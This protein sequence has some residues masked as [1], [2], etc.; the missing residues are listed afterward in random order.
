MFEKPTVRALAGYIDSARMDSSGSK[1]SHIAAIPRDVDLPL[2]FSQQRIWFLD[3][4]TGTST[5]Y[6]IP[7]AF[8]LKGKLDVDVLRRSIREIIARHEVLRTT[9]TEKDGKPVQRIMNSPA[10]DLEVIN[11]D[12]L[13][14]DERTT[15]IHRQI[16]EEAQTPFDL[17]QGPLI[18]F[19]LLHLAEME[20]ALFFTMHHI[21]F[22]R[23]S[24][25]V[26]NRELSLLYN[27]YCQ[28]QPSPL[29]ELPIQYADYAAWQRQW[30]KGEKLEEQL[31]FWKEQLRDITALELHSDRPR[32]P[33][34]TFNGNTHIFQISPSLTDALH[35][36]NRREGATLFMTLLAVFQ[37]L[38]HRYTGNDNIVVGTPI[39]NRNRGDIEGLIGFFINT[40]VIHTDISG[41]PTFREV[42][43]RVRKVMLDAY[44]HQDMPFEK[45]VE[46][47]Q[48]ERDMSRT[49][50]FQVAF[51]LQ[52]EPY[53]SLEFS[54][55]TVS[56]V[57]IESPTAMFD[58]EV[59]MREEE[60]GIR[61]IVVYNTDLFDL[62]TIER[63]TGHYHR[64]LSS[65]SESPDQPVS[66]IPMLT[67]AER[68][69]ILTEWNDTSMEYPGNKC[70]HELFEAYVEKTPDA[71]AVI[72]GDR[73]LTY[74]ELNERANQLA[75]YLKSQGV[76]PEVFAGICLER[77]P[78][79]L[80]GILGILKAGGAYV[81]LDPEYP[82]ERL[83]FMLEDT[84][85]PVVLTLRSMVDALPVYNG[86]I[87]RL[88]S[89]LKFIERESKENPVSGAVSS[90]AA[91]IMY[92]SG[93]TGTPKGAVILHRSV[94]RLVSNT[95]YIKLE[96]SD[97]V[98]QIS[99]FSF[100]ASTFEVWGA[101]LNGACLV[102][103]PK[104]VI[105]SPEIFASEISKRKISVLLLT[106]AMFNKMASEVPYAFSSLR[107][108][109]FGGEAVDPTSV[110]MVLEE[111]PP[112]NLLNFYGPA[113]NTVATSWYRVEN[114]PEKALTIPIGKPVSNTTIYILD[115]SL[116]PV[117]VGITGELYAGGDGLAREY[118]N[119]P[120]LTAEKFVQ[121]PFNEE[122]GKRLYKTGDLARYM[123]DGTIEFLGRID[124]QVKIRGFRIEP[125][126]IEAVLGRHPDVRETVVIVREKQPGDKRLIAYVVL[127]EKSDITT[128]KLRSFLKATMPE[129]MVPTA[130]V[131]LDS[132]PLT[133]NRKID[134]EA[135]PEPDSERP[136]SE[137]PYVGP[138]TSIE[139]LIAGIL[140]EVLE[141]REVGIHDN[142]FELG[143]HSLLATQV[144]S[145]LRNTLGVEI[146]LQRLFERPTVEGLSDVISQNAD[147]FERL[148]KKAELFLRVS[149]LSEEE[150]D[151]MFAE[152]TSYK[153]D[154]K[155]E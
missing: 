46:E 61:G 72:S 155:D 57:S 143:G 132:L 113:E 39:A 23:W 127:N 148:E 4:L 135:L 16:G 84:G 8:L 83:A 74:K 116:Q 134:R 67:D 107:Y 81:P 33:V 70:I 38:L 145:L 56:P 96:R 26:L 123:P 87:I 63:M 151:T 86:M 91:H 43:K 79:M 77:S 6:N 10:I 49:P 122:P 118:L 21:V 17:E 119:R 109:L 138:R 140:C 37:C 1:D 111:G 137:N 114:V 36:L 55:L 105:L 66:E 20:Y 99:T 103:I 40:L 24:S 100:D 133:P 92:T 121:D 45:L 90:G 89:D 47:L 22:D 7:Q 60:D 102:L 124:H 117:P 3:R 15:Q 144:I 27:A 120:E 130:F 154:I 50:L 125:G 147:E 110:S 82:K 97:V 19:K 149:E 52:N 48:P 115:S 101:L 42:L 106:T 95:N 98:A 53:S 128:G 85:T 34:Q 12:N 71:L 146:P 131:M 41:S 59:H 58:M 69:Q 28:G 136:D 9:F 93:S 80:I 108:L 142:F 65:I 11:C 94:V 75:H 31:G 62:S 32:P 141:L 139:K 44:A 13:P 30:L 152:G 150:A 104:D 35:A 2:S 126:E 25:E 73:R 64:L 76:G 78:E 112:Q 14:G 153:E 51:A 29:P 54:G 18:R 88:D 68:H 129:Y 5:M